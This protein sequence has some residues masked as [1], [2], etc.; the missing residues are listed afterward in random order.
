MKQSAKYDTTKLRSY[1]FLSSEA[2]LILLR[3]SAGFAT[4]YLLLSGGIDKEHNSHLI[5]FSTCSCTVKQTA[6]GFC[7]KDQEAMKESRERGQVIPTIKFKG[8]A[9]K[10]IPISL[11]NEP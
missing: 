10:F 7:S 2:S 6:R 11:K 3:Q 1:F 5:A 8:S 4:V 9:Q